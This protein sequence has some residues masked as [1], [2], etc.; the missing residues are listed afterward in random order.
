MIKF[1]LLESAGSV[2]SCGL[3]ISYSVPQWELQIVCKWGLYLENLIYMCM[4]VGLL[5]VCYCGHEANVVGN[6]NLESQQLQNSWVQ[7][8]NLRVVRT[9]DAQS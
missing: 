3:L 5:L 7:V 4:Y 8:E 9:L 1:H 6:R 2:P